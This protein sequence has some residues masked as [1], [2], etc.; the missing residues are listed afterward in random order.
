MGLACCKEYQQVIKE[1]VQTLLKR[2]HDAESDTSIASHLLAIRVEISTL[3]AVL[4][5]LL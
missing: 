5:A 1:L 2:Q 3:R 4:H